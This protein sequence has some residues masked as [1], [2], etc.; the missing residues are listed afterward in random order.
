LAYVSQWLPI[1]TILFFKIWEIH[2]IKIRTVLKLRRT[3]MKKKIMLLSLLLYT[4][5]AQAQSGSTGT[6]QINSMVLNLNN[7]EGANFVNYGSGNSAL[8]MAQIMEKFGPIRVCYP[9]AQVLSFTQN[10]QPADTNSNL[11]IIPSNEANSGTG[12]VTDGRPIFIIALR[13]GRQQHVGRTRFEVFQA[14][15][16]GIEIVQGIS[17]NDQVRPV[18][19]RETGLE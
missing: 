17:T 5:A 16:N 13:N 14:L 3:K 10:P 11:I 7:C 12:I 15:A 18:D 8:Q 2:L 6:G 1:I 4:F 9:S 19:P